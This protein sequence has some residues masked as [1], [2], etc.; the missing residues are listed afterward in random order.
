MNLL[1]DTCTFIW[2]VSEPTKLPASAL[3]YFQDPANICYLSS[4]ST[5][6]IGVLAGLGRMHFAEPVERFVPR[7][8]RLQRIRPLRLLESAALLSAKLPQHHRDPFDRML[9][10]QAIAHGMTI[11]TP[12]EKIAK[13]AVP[14]LW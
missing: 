4:V 10:C 1:L 5:W 2:V 11:L 7:M 8:R 13:Y 14:V 12:D 3:A 9:I 6:E